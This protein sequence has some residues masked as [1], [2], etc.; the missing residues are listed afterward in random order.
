MNPDFII[1]IQLTFLFELYTH[2]TEPLKMPHVSKSLKSLAYL[3]SSLLK[4]A[5]SQRDCNVPTSEF[6][7]SGQEESPHRMSTTKSQILL[8]IYLE[9]ENNVNS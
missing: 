5:S 6:Q 7:K 2:S 8:F 9:D 3:H 4:T 1:H